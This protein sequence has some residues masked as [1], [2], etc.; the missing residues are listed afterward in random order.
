LVPDSVC[1]PVPILVK[2]TVP[3]SFLM[4]PLKVPEP[5]LLPTVKVPPEP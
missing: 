1:V 3:A 2:A 5:L 4:T